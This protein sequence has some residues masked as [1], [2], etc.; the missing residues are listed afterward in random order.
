MKS[1]LSRIA[2]AAVGLAALSGCTRQIPPAS[3]G[4]QFNA[5]SGISRKLIRPQVVWLAPREQLII[6]PTS[7]HNAT[8]VRSAGEG[9]RAGDDSIKASTAEGAILPVDITVAYHVAPEDVLKAFNNFGADELPE[10]QKTFIRW[11]TIS[12][13]NNVA[14]Q[15]S[16]FD[17]SS[18]ERARFG[19]DVKKVIAPTLADWGITVDDVYIGEVY[20]NDEIRSR[21]DQ[22]IALRNQLELAKNQRQQAGIDAQTM[23]TNATKNAELNRLLQQGTD[24]SVELKRMELRRLAIEKWDGRTPM[25]GDGGIPFTDIRVR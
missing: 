23:M 21:I 1:R 15:K 5:S 8:Y 13:V 2:V 16:I 18:K 9:E 20:P 22:R 7:I 6:Y 12:G 14:G 19:G 24:K 11:T 10:I 17:L 3:V 4:V 25:V